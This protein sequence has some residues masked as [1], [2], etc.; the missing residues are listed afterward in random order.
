MFAAWHLTWQTQLAAR[1]PPADWREALW[2]ALALA[3]AVLVGIIVIWLVDRWRKGP[4]G[5]KQSPGDQL[6]HFRDLHSRGEISDA[7][8]ERIRGLLGERR[9][10]QVDMPTS[11]HDDRP[12]DPPS[13]GPRPGQDS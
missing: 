1:V 6:A 13:T 8:L 2:A 12:P 3:G 4:S 9:R 7:E 5:A 10:D 11:P